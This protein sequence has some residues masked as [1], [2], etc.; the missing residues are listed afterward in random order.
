MNPYYNNRDI[1]GET[2]A[3][4][5]RIVNSEIEHDRDIIQ[6]NKEKERIKKQDLGSAAYEK[7]MRI[8]SER[9]LKNAQDNAV[10][11]LLDRDALVNT[12]KFLQEK[13]APQKKEEFINDAKNKVEDIYEKDVKDQLKVDKAHEIIEK[14]VNSRNY[15]PPQIPRSQYSK[16]KT[17][18]R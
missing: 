8:V 14:N 12:I 3:A 10:A 9:K 15:K 7:Q 11:L 6:A 16:N 5:Q 18:Y 13:W 17:K 1:V 2:V 4:N